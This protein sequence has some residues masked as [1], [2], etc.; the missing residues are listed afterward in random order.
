MV[1]SGNIKNGIC[2]F[3]R[4]GILLLLLVLPV[5]AGTSLEGSNKDLN[6]RKMIRS[7]PGEKS[8]RSRMQHA[9]KEESKEPVTNHQISPWNK[10]QV[11]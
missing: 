3:I 2:R 9:V 6:G 10:V 8:D 7:Y 4:P 5:N 1:P 11:F